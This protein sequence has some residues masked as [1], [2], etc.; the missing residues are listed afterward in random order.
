MPRNG[1]AGGKWGSA[2]LTF[3]DCDVKVVIDGF[4]DACS[5]YQYY[6]YRLCGMLIGMSEEVTDGTA[7]ASYLTAKN[8]TVTYGD[9]ANY[10]Y[11]ESESYG[12]GSYAAADEWKFKRVQEGYATEGVDPNH[13]HDT[14]ESHEELFVFDQLFGGDKGVRGGKT[15]EGVTVIYN[16]K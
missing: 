7:T 4:N 12:K 8:C 11:C 10:T 5:N 15:H 16:N 14:D 3:E 1:R 13:T 6:N 2:E 9:W